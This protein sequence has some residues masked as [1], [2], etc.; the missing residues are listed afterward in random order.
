MFCA[1]MGQKRLIML[2]FFVLVGEVGIRLQVP[3]PPTI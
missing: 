2:G 3:E 1:G